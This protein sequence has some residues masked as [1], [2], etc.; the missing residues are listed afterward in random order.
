MKFD[1]ERL[2]I[3]GLNDTLSQITVLKTIFK[4]EYYLEMNEVRQ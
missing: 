3:K 1:S 4:Y 2:K